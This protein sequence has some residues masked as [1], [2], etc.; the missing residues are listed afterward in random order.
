MACRSHSRSHRGHG[1]SSHLFC[2]GLRHAKNT[3]AGEVDCAAKLRA[4]TNFSSRLTNTLC[5]RSCARR[6]A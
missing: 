1:G 5:L 2:L 3:K 4:P 6:R